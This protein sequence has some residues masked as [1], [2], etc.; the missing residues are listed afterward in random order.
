MMHS[1]TADR[2][3]ASRLARLLRFGTTIAV[4]VTSIGMLAAH[5]SFTGVATAAIVSGLLMFAL[6]PIAG[7]LAAMQ[8]YVRRLD[9]T[10]VAL[11][12]GVFVL[13]GANFLVS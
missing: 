4:T 3:L 12:V 2:G 6:L 1:E 7:L 10:Y 9:W 11:T 13:V 8:H 5:T